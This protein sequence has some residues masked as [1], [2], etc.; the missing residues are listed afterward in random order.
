[1]SK[2]LDNL[3]WLYKIVRQEMGLRIRLYATNQTPVLIYQMGK[4]ASTSIFQSLKQAGIKP[5]FHTHIM[6]PSP[7]SRE[8]FDERSIQIPNIKFSRILLKK[9]GAFLYNSLIAKNKNLKIIS[10]TREPIA[11][12]ISY[13]FHNFETE[14][15]KKPDESQ[16]TTQEL[17]DIF[18]KYFPHSRPLDW[19]DDQLK[20]YLKIDVYGYPFPKDSGVLTI[21]KDNV[22]LLLLKLE[23][24]DRVKEKAIAE[25]LGLKEFRL[26]RTNVGEDK[27]YRDMYKEFKQSLKLPLSYVEEMC[28][29]KYFNHFYTEEEIKKVYSRWT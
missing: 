7:E 23:T 25:F 1:M 21:H 8:Y 3:N 6:F 28:S 11:W 24:T 14:T 26:V 16:F 29:S 20:T 22:D 18:L 27:N 12:N 5:V 15:G 9:K 2:L 17:V 13:F 19:F 10:L 4:V